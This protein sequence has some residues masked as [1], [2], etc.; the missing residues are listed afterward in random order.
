MVQQGIPLRK[1]LGAFRA[2][3]HMHLLVGQMS[4]EVDV[5]Q[6]L[7]GEDGVTHDALIDRPANTQKGQT[8]EKQ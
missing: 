4:V 5:K 3:E 7:V 1:Q 2:L 8:T 6:G